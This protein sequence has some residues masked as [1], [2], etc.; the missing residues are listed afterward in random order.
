MIAIL[1]LGRLRKLAGDRRGNVLA[2][3]AFALPVLLGGA[4]LAVDTT[5]WY[6]WKRELQL[7]AD[8]GA[9]SGAY[10]LSQGKDHVARARADATANINVA[11]LTGTPQVTQGD[12]GGRTNNAVTV[13]LSARHRLAFSSMFLPTPP[14]ITA[15]ATAAMVNDGDHCMIS[16]DN[17][18]EHAI[19]IMGNATVSLGCGISSNSRHK[20]AIRVDGSAKVN[21][22]PLSAV[23]NI[24]ADVSHLVGQT[25]KRPYSLPQPDPLAGLTAKASPAA[26]PAYDKD[27]ELLPTGTYT[28]GL[29]IKGDHKLSGLYVFEGGTISLGAKHSLTGTALIVL[30][31][32]AEFQI[33]GGST[34]S[35]QAPTE[36]Q[37]ASWNYTSFGGVLIFEDRATSVAGKTSTLNGNAK[38]HLN[39]AIYLPTQ[40]VRINGNAEPTTQCLLLVARTIEVSGDAILPS[41]CPAGTHSQ[42]DIAARVVRLVK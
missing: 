23:G 24:D 25:T 11:D 33:N 3:T 19:D 10:A 9:L 34:I 29:T 17:E 41:A 15:T 1:R 6:L 2:L 12:W 31:N 20:E 40:K 14:T 39:G 42:F 37:A 35:L 21:A 5:Q 36:T 27:V 18:V 26:A 4:G 32:G 22:N 30:K 28:G 8:A 38:L 13:S 7:A 16:L